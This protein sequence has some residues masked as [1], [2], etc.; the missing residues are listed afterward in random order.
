M[1]AV[2]LEFVHLC[3]FYRPKEHGH[4]RHVQQCADSMTSGNLNLAVCI[5]TF[6]CCDTTQGQS[7]VSLWVLEH[8]INITHSGALESDPQFP[9]E[10]LEMKRKRMSERI[11]LFNLASFDSCL[12]ICGKVVSMLRVSTAM[13]IASDNITHHDNSCSNFRDFP[14]TPGEK[15]W[16][17]FI[18]RFCYQFYSFIFF[19]FL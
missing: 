13:S 4:D 10:C 15:T 3:L 7:H 11:P 1:N 12:Q 16:K 8:V 14:Y 6:T 9:L 19:L 17:I 18:K 5:L 2:D